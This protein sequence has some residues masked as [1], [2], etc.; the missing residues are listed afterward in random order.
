MTYHDL[1]LSCSPTTVHSSGGETFTCTAAGGDQ[2]YTW[3][4]PSIVHEETGST[5]T[6]K[7][8]SIQLPTQSSYPTDGTITIKLQDGHNAVKEIK[9]ELL[10]PGIYIEEIYKVGN[11]GI[12]VGATEDLYFQLN[13]VGGLQDMQT[14]QAKLLKGSCANSTTCANK[15]IFNVVT[16][17][18]QL[19]GTEETGS[20]VNLL[21]N[22]LYKLPVLIPDYEDLINGDYTYAVTVYDIYNQQ[23]TAY[24]STYIGTLI[25]GDINGDQ[26]ID[27]LDIV[28]TVMYYLNPSLEMKASERDAIDFNNN[29]QIDLTDVI[30]V[31]Q[32]AMKE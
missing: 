31:I 23:T 29:Q 9:V 26:S 5:D 30:K 27:I 10:P 32:E 7:T 20:G 18:A 25:D 16:S 15:Q 3:L 8:F 28:K 21:Y 24:L 12:Q 11:A 13:A 17:S 22:L 1:S 4:F 6:L 14:I 19:T 2:E